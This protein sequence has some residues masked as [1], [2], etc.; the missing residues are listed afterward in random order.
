MELVTPANRL[1]QPVSSETPRLVRRYQ[2]LPTPLVRDK[3]ANW[4]SG[5]LDLVLQGHFDIIGS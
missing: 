2:E 4:R 3:I 1:P 5:R